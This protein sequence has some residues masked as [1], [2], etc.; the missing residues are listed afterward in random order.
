YREARAEARRSVM[1][2]APVPAGPVVT[3][4]DG[5]RA[6]LDEDAWRRQIARAC[7]GL[8]GVS[9]D[10]LLADA[11]RNI[12]DG[13]PA[14]EL[15]LATIMAA[16]VLID[17]D[18]AYTFVA[19]RLLLDDLVREATTF[20]LGEP[21]GADVDYGRYFPAF[22]ERGIALGLLPR[23]RRSFDLAKLA[24]AIRPER[25]REF[26]FLGLQT[27]YDRYLQ[28]SDGTR[29]ELPQAF[30]M[31]VAMGLAEREPDRDARAVQFYDV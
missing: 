21:S 18:P 31:R 4:R 5:T 28:H 15:Q 1:P 19:A 3:R 24:A 27:L 17:V 26:Q 6:P 7:E 12:Y 30:F 25:D 13:I 8:E 14:D 10:R 2:A 11:R 16:R 29:L 9:V 20:V 22:V 23:D